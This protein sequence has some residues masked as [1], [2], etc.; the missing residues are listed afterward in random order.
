MHLILPFAFIIDDGTYEHSIRTG[1][2]ITNLLSY[3]YIEYFVDSLNESIGD[4]DKYAEFE[5][6]KVLREIDK[7]LVCML[8]HDDMDIHMNDIIEEVIDDIYDKMNVD[9]KIRY[10]PHKHGKIKDFNIYFTYI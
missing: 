1:S 8:T 7:R 4:N 10:D 9:I 2:H 5:Y 3:Q 6:S